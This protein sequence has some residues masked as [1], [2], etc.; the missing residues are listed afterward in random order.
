M[1]VSSTGV[2]DRPEATVRGDYAYHGKPLADSGTSHRDATSQAQVDS[3]F[4]PG[5]S[6]SFCKGIVY[7]SF[8]AFSHLTQEQRNLCFP[9]LDQTR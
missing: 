2:P 5:R 3:R 4:T 6:W 7:L 1:Q 9:A 8:T